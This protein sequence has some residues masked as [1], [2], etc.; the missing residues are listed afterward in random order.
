MKNQMISDTVRKRWIHTSLFLICFCCVT[1]GLAQVP[2]TISYQGLLSDA[3]G[4]AVRDGN[5]EL[6][7]TLYDAE[8]DGRALWK[9]T[10]SVAVVNGVFNVILGSSVPF[11]L[12]FDEPY[13]L[14]I[15]VGT[16]DELQPRIELTASPYSMR[17]RS[18]IDSSVTAVNIA[19][20]QVVRS[21]NGLTDAV[22]IVAGNNMG[23]SLQNNSIVLSSQGGGE[24]SLPFDD[25][26]ETD[27]F[28]FAISN[29]GT[30]SVA[31]FGSTNEDRVNAVLDVSGQG[32]GVV[33]NAFSRGAGSAAFFE[34]TD[35][36]NT[37]PVIT[38]Q[39]RGL[40][41]AGEFTIL[42]SNNINPVLY[43]TN[44]GA[45]AAISAD[46]LN[47]DNNTP[48]LNA[49]TQGAGPV[50]RLDKQNV[51]GNIAEFAKFGQVRASIDSAGNF[52][53]TGNINIGNK[54]IFPDGTEQTSAA[55]GTGQYWNLTG[56]V[57]ANPDTAFLGTRDQQPFEI[58]VNNKRALRLEQV[59]GVAD[60][61]TLNFIAGGSS[62]S[63]SSGVVGATISGG[64]SPTD[65]NRVIG[66]YGTIG[67]GFSNQVASHAFIGGGTTNTAGSDYTVVSGGLQN[68]ASSN[69]ATVGGGEQ[70]NASDDHATISGGRSNQ[71][72]AIHATVGGGEQNEASGFH[73]TVAGGQLNQASGRDATVGGGE[74]NSAEHSGDTVSGGEENVAQGRETGGAVVGGGQS[75]QAL[76]DAVTVSGGRSNL[77]SGWI[78]T[79]AGGRENVASSQ[80][81][82]IGGGES[83]Q[84]MDSYSTIGGGRQN[85]ASGEYATVPGGRQN[86]ARGLYSFAAGYEARAIHEGSFVW[87]DRSAT[88]GNDSLVT[89]AVNQ[90][91]IRAEG[92]VGIGT[93]APNSELSV[94]GDVD[95]ETYQANTDLGST[96]RPATGGVYQD[97][98]V[99]AWAR[100]NSDGSIAASF[101]CTVERSFTGTYT[102]TYNTTLSNGSAPVVTPLSAND[103]VIATVAGDLVSSCTVNLKAFISNAFQAVDNPFLIQIV[104]RP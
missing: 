97:N 59:G 93:N 73:S 34:V 102:V 64:G 2:Q 98:V 55:F 22:N 101:G 1:V 35:A 66:D 62:N 39:N 19:D 79:I 70:N 10:Q 63:V 83:N 29:T 44:K 8:S 41:S 28:A 14:G 60:G 6:T 23:L 67:G 16:D 17:A 31:R 76:H 27:G 50:L 75:N 5:Y 87:N 99:Y 37:R 90:F 49:S 91:L 84:A 45:S 85:V 42:N 61:A 104:G 69:Y 24:F 92:G 36:E 3:D 72:S 18:V 100:V 80:H 40:G 11:E 7:F 81:T 57:N 13:W 74:N 58:R 38:A 89:T 65:R 25:Q 56:N 46:N 94:A 32:K 4:N 26:V 54:L 96:A 78:S 68:N 77:A 20:D 33:M 15:Q 103:P 82:T 30:G 95:A 43:V 88:F 71:A 12:P 21:L 9:E 86:Q 53:T 47:A 52:F 51:S 48:V